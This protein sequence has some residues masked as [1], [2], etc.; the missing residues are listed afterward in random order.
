[1]DFLGMPELER[2]VKLEGYGDTLL[3]LALQQF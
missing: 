2:D 3:N 1:M